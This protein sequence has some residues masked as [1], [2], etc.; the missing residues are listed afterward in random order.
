MRRFKPSGLLWS[1]LVGVGGCVLPG[2]V[3]SIVP[4]LLLVPR[5][6]SFGS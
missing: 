4:Q 1:G 2:A 5:S 6:T 3:W